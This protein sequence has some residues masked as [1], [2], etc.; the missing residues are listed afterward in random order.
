[1]F[2]ASDFFLELQIQY[3]FSKKHLKV[4]TSW[5]C[6]ILQ[7][8]HVP[9]S[10]MRSPGNKV[11]LRSAP[12]CGICNFSSTDFLGKEIWSNDFGC[13]GF[14][15]IH[16]IWYFLIIDF[17]GVWSCS[18]IGIS[19][20]TVFFYRNISETMPKQATSVGH[21]SEKDLPVARKPFFHQPPSRPA[22]SLTAAFWITFPPQSI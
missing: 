21:L 16:Q 7:N 17:E 8:W 13:Q 20:S 22:I 15:K 5:I 18:D 19:C 6:G 2:F 10:T 11:P 9:N 12:R 1:M 3:M 14:L 4:K